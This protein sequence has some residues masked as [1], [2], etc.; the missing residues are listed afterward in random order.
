MKVCNNSFVPLTGRCAQAARSRYNPVVMLRRSVFLLLSVCAFVVCGFALAGCRTARLTAQDMPSEPATP[1][2]P[3]PTA[4]STPTVTPLPSATATTTPTATPLPSPTPTPTATP[5]PL[6]VTGDPFAGLRQPPQIGGRYPCGPVDVLDFPVD[7]PDAAQVSRG[8]QD[9]GVYRSRYEKYHAGEDW[10]APDGRASLGMPVYSIGHGLVTFAAPLGWGADQG[11]VI[12]RHWLGAE[13]EIL[14]FYGHLEP[15]S[16]TLTPGTCVARGEQ[17]GRVGRPRT[18]PHLHFE[19]RTQSAYAPLTGY[20]P[21]DPQTVGWLPPS[22]TIWQQR[23]AAQPGIQWALPYTTTA[24]APLGTLLDGRLLLGS[25]NGD[26]TLIDAAA[27]MRRTLAAERA[28]GAWLV[29]PQSGQL[30]A[31]ERAGGL[32]GWGGDGNQ[33]AALWRV[34]TGSARDSALLPLPG[35]GVLLAAAST[36]TAYAANGLLLWERNWEGN[37]ADLSWDL[38]GQAL[39]FA[40]AAGVW[41]IV[42]NAPPRQLVAGI[43]GTL[44]V[45]G[46]QRW[47]AGPE[48][49]YRMAADGGLQVVLARP[50]GTPAQLLALPD[51]AALLADGSSFMRRLVLLAADGQIVWQRGLFRAVAGEVALHLVDGQ[52]Y[53]VAAGDGSASGGPALY[54]IDLAAPELQRLWQG[55]TRTPLPH[56]AWSAAV[57]LPGG[58]GLLIQTGG[59]ALV[60]WRPAS[61]VAQ[62]E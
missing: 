39:Y 19:I 3:A 42:D 44:A 32:S 16:I 53:L 36:L 62:S 30:Y 21:E 59:G 43:G 27:G 8:G 24:S 49:V 17:I 41:R 45:G 33:L 25:R 6:P 35:D 13:R 46:G 38:D 5:L 1:Q 11:V 12:V 52:P 48:A 40:D 2:P 34:E 57:P 14:S 18:P 9:F 23:S 47:L 4:T 26:L 10:R 60:L 22:Q 54:R 29:H 15:E 61:Q 56:Y 58:E 20:W 7:P 50:A 31:L 51:G 37:A 55:G 28:V